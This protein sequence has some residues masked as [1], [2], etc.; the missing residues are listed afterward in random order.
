MFSQSLQPNCLQLFT[1]EVQLKAL[2]RLWLYSI[3]FYVL[4]FVRL[5]ARSPG[6]KCPGYLA[7]AFFVFLL[8]SSLISLVLQKYVSKIWHQH[9]YV[10][11]KQRAWV[12]N[13]IMNGSACALQNGRLQH[14]K[15]HNNLWVVFLC[16][17]V[18]LVIAIC[19]VVAI[20]LTVV[21]GELS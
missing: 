1:P 16:N 9:I 4:R 6:W 8:S 2:F 7:V 18:Q 12:K 5:G 15:C 13:K 11:P 19:V 14:H 3:Y 21:V 17:H 10:L 20:I